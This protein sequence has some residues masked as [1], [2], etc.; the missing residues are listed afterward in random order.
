MT[1]RIKSSPSVAARNRSGIQN[2]LSDKMQ[3]KCDSPPLRL[4]N[5]PTLGKKTLAVKAT[6][7]PRPKR[8]EK[9]DV[10]C[11]GIVSSLMLASSLLHEN[12]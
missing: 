11:R 6:K 2:I 5:I 9:R 8:N 10:F 4:A 3:F 12:Q 7:K 1:S